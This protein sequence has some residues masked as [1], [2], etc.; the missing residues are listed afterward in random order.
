MSD[1]DRRMEA[2]ERKQKQQDDTNGRGKYLFGYENFVSVVDNKINDHDD[3]IRKLQNEIKMLKMR[4]KTDNPNSSNT[5][6][7]E[8]DGMGAD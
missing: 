8:N 1:F 7:P 4:P 6:A 3:A 2:A 5:V